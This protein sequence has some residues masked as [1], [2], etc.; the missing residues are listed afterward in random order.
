MAIRRGDIYFVD[1]NPT[2][3]REQ[4]GRRPVLVLSIDAINR[5]PLVVT[6]VVG[7]KGENLSRDHLT[8]V[9]VSSTESGLPQETVFLCFQIR[10]LD[11]GRFPATSAGKVDEETLAKIENTV[12]YCLGL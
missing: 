4:S 5:L 2:H 8:N 1:L 11:P 7:T 3:G 9:R 10:S 12:R 6:V